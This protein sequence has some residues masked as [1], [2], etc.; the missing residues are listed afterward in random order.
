MVTLRPHDGP[1]APS[2]LLTPSS[3]STLRRST[4]SAR[5]I[6]STRSLVGTSG[7]AATFRRLADHL[8]VRLAHSPSSSALRSPSLTSLVTTMVQLTK[9]KTNFAARPLD[10]LARRHL[11]SRRHTPAAGRP[12][13]WASWVVEFRLHGGQQIRFS[14]TSLDNTAGV[15]GGRTPTPR[16]PTSTSL[17][18]T[19]ST[20]RT[21]P[22]TFEVT[23]SIFLNY[24]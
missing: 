14:F 4:C 12:P 21:R 10:S 19:R 7:L 9:T 18:S 11:G 24:H 6:R 2:G 22:S 8:R 1:S 20:T 5:L 17:Y 15:V 23:S 3:S 13:P 16:R